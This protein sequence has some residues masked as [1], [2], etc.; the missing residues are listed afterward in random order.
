LFYFLIQSN[1]RIEKTKLDFEVH[2][3]KEHSEINTKNKMKVNGVTDSTLLSVDQFR[4]MIMKV[5]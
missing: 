3:N 1:T 2:W 4:E 5:K